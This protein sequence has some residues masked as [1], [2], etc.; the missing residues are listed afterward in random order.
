MRVKDGFFQIVLWQERRFL[1][2]RQMTISNIPSRQQM[3]LKLIA[4]TFIRYL[5]RTV[6]R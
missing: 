5:T 2:G 4:V 6:V 3:T 1:Y